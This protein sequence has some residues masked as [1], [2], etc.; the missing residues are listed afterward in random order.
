MVSLF[1]NQFVLLG[2]LMLLISANARAAQPICNTITECQAL[3]AQVDAP[4]KELQAG[5]MPTFLDIAK[6]AAGP[7]LMTQPAAVEYCQDPSNVQQPAHL[8][9]A[10]ELAQL[11]MSLGAKGI[12]DTCGKD[13]NCYKISN[14]QNSDGSKDEF[15]Y[16]Y[17]GYQR[18]PGDL[19]SNW[20]WSSSV[21]S[22]YSYYAFDLNGDVGDVDSGHRNRDNFIAVRCVSGR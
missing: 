7:K 2:G 1:R 3:R 15:Y 5:Q 10:R 21:Y 17:S 8:P 16:S 4:I 14:I 22:G 12:V 11:S 6:N 20:F 19:G 9:S 13:Q 18:P